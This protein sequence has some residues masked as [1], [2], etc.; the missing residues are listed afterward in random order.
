MCIRKDLRLDNETLLLLYVGKVAVG[1]GIETIIY[2]L[3]HLPDNV[4][5][6]T[7]GPCDHS[8]KVKMFSLAKKLRLNDE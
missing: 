3:P 8:M 2:N 5:F 1:R 4:V 6:A 7:V